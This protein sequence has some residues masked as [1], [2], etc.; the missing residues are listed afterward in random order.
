MDQPLVRYTSITREGQE[1]DVQEAKE[2]TKS[3]MPLISRPDAEMPDP[4][5]CHPAQCRA[6]DECNPVLPSSAANSTS[7]ISTSQHLTSSQRWKR[8]Y[9]QEH[10]LVMTLREQLDVANAELE[11][12]YHDNSQLQQDLEQQ[13]TRADHFQ[14][15]AAATLQQSMAPYLAV[16][17]LQARDQIDFLV[18]KNTDLEQH[19]KVAIDDKIKAEAIAAKETKAYKCLKMFND[20]KEQKILSLEAENEK[21]RS[22][23]GVNQLHRSHTE[24]ARSFT[25]LM[26]RMGRPQYEVNSSS[27]IDKILPIPPPLVGTT[28]DSH[29]SETASS[30]N[31]TASPAV[32]QVAVA[33]VKIKRASALRSFHLPEHIKRNKTP[34]QAQGEAPTS[35]ILVGPQTTSTSSRS[36]LTIPFPAYEEPYPYPESPVLP[37][38]TSFTSS[39]PLYQPYRPYLQEG[40]QDEVFNDNGT[41]SRKSSLTVP[42][43]TYEEPY[44]ES[45]ARWNATSSD[46]AYQPYRSSQTEDDEDEGKY[47][48]Q[49]EWHHLM[50]SE[51][52]TVFTSDELHIETSTSTSSRAHVEEKLGER[53]ETEVESGLPGVEELREFKEYILF[54][55]DSGR[56]VSY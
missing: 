5:R 51:Q 11:Q 22:Q 35:E 44:P 28:L 53:E 7:Y 15:A 4:L 33:D 6:T 46:Y 43:P 37:S 17:S 45:P 50:Q 23:L 47:E 19:V 29:A 21:L 16:G 32:S 39:N 36:S 52:Q 30:E 1:F 3:R 8:T 42:F 10:Q 48:E 24:P 27:N 2:L 25:V 34:F 55:W 40:E 56:R 14:Q 12:R 26:E 9:N 31:M 38:P 18:K 41:V 13:R 20:I 49:E 54:G